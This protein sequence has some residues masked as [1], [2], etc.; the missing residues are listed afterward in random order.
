[1]PSSESSIVV[2]D[3]RGHEGIAERALELR[4]DVEHADPGAGLDPDR[5]TRLEVRTGRVRADDFLV[6]EDGSLDRGST[7]KAAVRGHR[8]DLDHTGAL[9]VQE[10][11]MGDVSDPPDPVAV[12]DL[13]VQARAADLAGS[14]RG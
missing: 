2:R 4:S 7:R 11:G 1:M 8:F 10:A 5:V 12:A 13:L 3:L 6:R 9:L 14:A